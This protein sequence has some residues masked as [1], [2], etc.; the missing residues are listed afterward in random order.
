MQLSIMFW[1]VCILLV[2]PKP[3]KFNIRRWVSSVCNLQSKM[4]VILVILI[5]SSQFLLFSLILV[6][7]LLKITLRLHCLTIQSPWNIIK[8]TTWTQHIFKPSLLQQGSI[9]GGDWNFEISDG[10]NGIH[11]YW[12][13][14]NC[15][16]FG[17]MSP[18]YI[19]FRIWILSFLP[20]GG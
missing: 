8:P 4:L 13:L 15:T 17:R 12:K 9:V 18:H 6:V 1:K 16:V 14:T 19:C 7:D 2:V 5:N 3:N 20:E 10:F 11:R